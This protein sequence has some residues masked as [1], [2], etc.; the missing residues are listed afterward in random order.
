MDDAEKLAAKQ[1]LFLE[2]LTKLSKQLAREY[3]ENLT[4]ALH[5]RSVMMGRL[6]Y[7]GLEADQWFYDQAAELLTEKGLPEW[8][9]KILIEQTIAG[10]IARFRKQI[11]ES[12]RIQSESITSELIEHQS[13]RKHSAGQR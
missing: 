1:L 10:R 4:D 9:F 6:C 8:R 7:A 13:D 12:L 5:E 3:G 11:Q 2:E